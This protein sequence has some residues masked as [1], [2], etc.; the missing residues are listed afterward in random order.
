MDTMK[1]G[2]Y[3]NKGTLEFRP[4]YPLDSD[5]EGEQAVAKKRTAEKVY[6]CLQ[7]HWLFKLY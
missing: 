3:V 5:S 7:L 6:A 4:K 2:F 1:G